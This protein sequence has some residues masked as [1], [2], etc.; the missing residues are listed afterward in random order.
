MTFLVKNI[1]LHVWLKKNCM[2]VMLY[3][4]TESHQLLCCSQI[5]K[6]HCIQMSHSVTSFWR[7]D[8]SDGQGWPWSEVLPCTRNSLLFVTPFKFTPV[9]VMMTLPFTVGDFALLRTGSYGWRFTVVSG[10]L[11]WC[12]WLSRTQVDQHYLEQNCITRCCASLSLHH[13]R[14]Q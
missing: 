12:T 6:E 14:L 13:I 1:I 4:N 7:N 5:E 9:C 11:C 8:I 10:T 3:R 2:R